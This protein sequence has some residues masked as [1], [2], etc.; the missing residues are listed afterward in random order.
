MKRRVLLDCDVVLDLL[1][2]RQP[3]YAAAVDLFTLLE[4]QEFVGCVTPLAYSN[5]F[6]V[7]RKAK[8]ADEAILALAK[9]RRLVEIV[10]IDSSITDDALA[11]SFR[12][13]EDALQYFAAKAHGLDAVVT[14]N[15]R[16]FRRA[17]LPILDAGECLRWLEDSSE[18]VPG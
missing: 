6:Y 16:D 10:A 13:F 12:D 3:H 17:Q 2:G 1:L 15:K 11:S 9:L 14:R 18:S 5:L 4:D 7:L 8:S